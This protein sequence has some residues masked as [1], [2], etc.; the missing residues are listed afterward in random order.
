MGQM[1]STGLVLG[2]LALL[3]SAALAEF[4]VPS[5]V[6]SAEELEQ[7]KTE[8]KQKGKPI[9]FLYSDDSTT[10]GLC[11]EASL[12]TLKEFRNKAVIVYVDTKKQN[13]NL[14]PKNV[15]ASFSSPESGRYIPKFTIFN[16]ELTSLIATVP[17]TRDLSA[18]DK[19]FRDAGKLLRTAGGASEGGTGTGVGGGGSNSSSF[20]SFFKKSGQ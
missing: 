5:N 17:Y 11:T 13:L 8:A 4:K 19:S 18:R 15:Q 1:K 7:A 6:H 3:S 16:S 10:C 9:A 20:D 2:C 14:L 12:S